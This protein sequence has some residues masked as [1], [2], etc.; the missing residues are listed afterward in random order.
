[1]LHGSLMKKTNVLRGEAA[2]EAPEVAAP[3][4]VSVPPESSVPAPTETS[5]PGGTEVARQRVGREG[6]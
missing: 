3:T 5:V 1:M 2:P 6:G 4:E